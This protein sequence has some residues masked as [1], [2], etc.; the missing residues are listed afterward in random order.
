MGVNVRAANTKHSNIIC[1]FRFPKG[2]LKY[3]TCLIFEISPREANFSP[4]LHRTREETAELSASRGILLSS[5]LTCAAG[6][7]VHFFCRQRGKQIK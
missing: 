2:T 1:I 5:F 4:K 6:L 7:R 3:P